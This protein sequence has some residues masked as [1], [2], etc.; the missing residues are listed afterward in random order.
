M[1]FVD[2]NKIL[3]SCEYDIVDYNKD[4]IEAY[5]PRLWAG[6]SLA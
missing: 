3:F 2:Y 6:P 4:V 5:L 1:I